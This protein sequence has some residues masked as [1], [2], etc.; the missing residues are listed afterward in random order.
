MLDTGWLRLIAGE[1]AGGSDYT[2]SIYSSIRIRWWSLHGRKKHGSTSPTTMAGGSDGAAVRQPT[3]A[4]S[5]QSYGFLIYGV[6]QRSL[7]RRL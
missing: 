3:L 2:Y 6:V 7:R 4:K 1:L 5:Q